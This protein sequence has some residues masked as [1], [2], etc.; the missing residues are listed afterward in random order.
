[1]SSVEAV[2][3]RPRQIAVNLL[4][5]RK[6]R[7]FRVR[8]WRLLNAKWQLRGATSVGAVLLEGRARV[9]NEGSIVI[10][11]GVKL[12]G[13]S[14]RIDFVAWRHGSIAIGEGTFVNYGTN[15]SAASKVVV[16][17]NCRIG[18]YT[19]IMDTDYHTPGALD[20]RSP[21]EPVVIEDNVWLG[22]RVIV[23]K[24]SRIGAGA[25]IGANSLVSGSIPP[26][27]IAAGSPAKVL[28]PI[29][30]ADHR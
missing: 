20:V 11:D 15:I 29:D 8:A 23:L 27:V 21:S 2:G 19:L 30:T 13:T 16:G 10:E 14:V 7:A 1:M 17:R 18:Q 28:R 25:V 24:G 12:D 3:R 22:A 4:R 9:R 6:F 26:G 5:R